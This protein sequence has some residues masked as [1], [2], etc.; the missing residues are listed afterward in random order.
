M[1]LDE[2]LLDLE[3]LELEENDELLELKLELDFELELELELELVPEQTLPLMV[4]NSTM[5][6]LVLPWNPKLMD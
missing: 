5:P 3:E 1:A 2:E 4:G 6:P